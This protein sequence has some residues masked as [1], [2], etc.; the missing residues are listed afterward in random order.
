MQTSTPNL[1]IEG[2]DQSIDE[3]AHYTLHSADPPHY[4]ELV[5]NCRPELFP[6]MRLGTIT[7][8]SKMETAQIALSARWASPNITNPLVDLRERCPLHAHLPF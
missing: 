8:H 3:S 1:Q 5:S 2:A 6:L 7:S 4:E